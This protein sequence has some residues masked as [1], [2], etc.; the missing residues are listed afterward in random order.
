MR[1]AISMILATLV[2]SACEKS[3]EPMKNEAI[4]GVETPAIPP[5]VAQKRDHELTGHGETRN[6][7]YYWMR[8]DDREDPDVLAYLNAENAYA[9]SILSRSGDLEQRLFDEMVAMEK[10]DDSSVPYRDGDYWYYARYEEGLDHPIFA[11]RHGSEDGEDEVLL[12]ENE[13]AEGYDYYR[14]GSTAASPDHSLMAFAADKVSRRNYDIQIK[15]LETGEILPDL[16]PH[17]S[18]ALAWAADNEHLFYVR[19]EEE[20]LIPNEVWRHKLGTDVSEDVLIY[21]EDDSQYVAFVYP[22]RDKQFIIVGLFSTLQTE[23]RLIPTN[24]P[25]AE[26]T[27]FLPRRDGHEYQALFAGDTAY[28]LTNNDAENFRIMSTQV[29]DS[30]DES[31]WKEVVPH[32]DDVF[33]SDVSVLDNYLVLQETESGINR[34]QVIPLDGSDPFYVSSDEPAYSAAI[35]NNPNL[36]TNVLRYSYSSLTT[37]ETIYD[38]DLSSN[39]RVQKKRDYAGDDFDPADYGTA[40]EYAIASDGERVPVTLLYRKGTKPDGS[41]PLYILGYGSYGSWYEPEFRST[42]LP[43][44]DRGFVFAIAHIRGGQEMGRRW[45]D[46]GKLL[47][48]KNTFTDF[49]DV[50][51]YLVERGWGAEGQV[52]GMGRSAGGLLIGAVAN[53]APDAF[54]VLVTAVPFVDVITTMQDE[55]IPLTT[56]EYDE[57]GNPADKEYFEYMMSY[58]PYDQVEAKD[59]PHLIVSTGLWDSQVQYWE[60]AKW[61]ARL[62]ANKTD[63]NLLVFYTDMSAGHGGGAGRFDRLRDTA[64]EHAFVLDVFGIAEQ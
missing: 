6:D 16:I 55:S 48:K 29:A 62:R 38:L 4:T 37:P 18:T 54:D 57:W 31:S 10:P 26:P 27:I 2:V 60:P 30:Q 63:D 43:L 40:R 14:I 36:D 12:D 52:V 25:L 23:F 34:L 8:D 21:R 17:S 42:V 9:K 50:A 19:R 51:N 13:L 64:R 3:P 1:A 33:I 28:V 39:E 44:V 5:P 22:S 24:E 32:R 41:H 61:V 58:S 53:M 35:D 7:P 11:R 46:D 59:Y 47:N 56:F 49:I 20:S 15:D 45:Y